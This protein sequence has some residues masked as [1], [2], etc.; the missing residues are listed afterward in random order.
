MLPH[1]EVD[2]QVGK[3][4]SA[5]IDPRL[6]RADGQVDGERSVS[7]DRDRQVV[8]RRGSPL[9][10]VGHE[11]HEQRTRAREANRDDAPRRTGGRR[12]RVDEVV[13]LAGVGSVHSDFT[14]R[15]T[16]PH[17]EDA[18]LEMDVEVRGRARIVA[19]NAVRAGE[20]DGARD[21]LGRRFAKALDG[22][23]SPDQGNRGD[24]GE[25]TGNGKGSGDDEPDDAV[26]ATGR[27]RRHRLVPPS[28][29]LD[30]HRTDRV[31]LLPRERPRGRPGLL[32][33]YA[34]G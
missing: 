25:R 34:T 20:R 33:P 16:R 29:G 22:G 12:V 24:G 18:V 9:H 13:V 31:P 1:R 6:S 27:L 17:F 7:R 2:G 5:E 14:A 8:R 11:L 21:R 4:Q 30:A 32:H 28:P 15:R 19:G 26:A 10:R 23:G 3:R